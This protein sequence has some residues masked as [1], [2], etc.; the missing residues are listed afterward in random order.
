MRCKA[1]GVA[2]QSVASYNQ[3]P[4]QW[5]VP[6]CQ[7]VWAKLDHQRLY[8]A[9]EDASPKPGFFGGR[10]GMRGRWWPGAGESNVLQL[11]SK[12]CWG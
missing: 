3:W 1:A 6:T 8:A 10:R 12:W 4:A 5:P 11:K 7:S 9:R 2:M